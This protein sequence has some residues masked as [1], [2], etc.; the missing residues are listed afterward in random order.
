MKLFLAGGLAGGILGYAYFYFIGCN[1]ACSITANPYIP[2][3]YGL[4][5][6]LLVAA[7]FKKDNDKADVGGKVSDKQQV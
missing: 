4:V 5:L 2:S 7:L 1:G 6:G 3:I